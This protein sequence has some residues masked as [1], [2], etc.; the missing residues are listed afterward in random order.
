MLNRRVLGVA[1]LSSQLRST[2]PTPLR[3]RFQFPNLHRQLNVS[4]RLLEITTTMGYN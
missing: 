2:Q 4:G 1:H 3:I